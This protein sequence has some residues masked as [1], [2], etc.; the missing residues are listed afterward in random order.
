MRKIRFLLVADSP[1]HTTGYYV[2][3]RA[4]RDAGVEVILGGH[5]Q[6]EEIVETAVQEDI[7]FIGYRIMDREPLLIVSR[8]REILSAR[9]LRHIRL[10]VGGIVARRAIP[11]LKELGVEE[12]FRPGTN[13]DDIA[14]HVTGRAAETPSAVV[15]T[16]R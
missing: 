15:V 5:A 4:L 7:D 11:G 9:G 12:V 16:R 14:S 1:G 3:A 8:L 6:P 13:L 2:V 10:V